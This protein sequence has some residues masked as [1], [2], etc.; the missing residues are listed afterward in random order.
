MQERT[1]KR[2]ETHETHENAR[3][4]ELAK[5]EAAARAVGLSYG[6]Y[7]AQAYMNQP[8]PEKA[9]TSPPEAR[10]RAKKYDD[11]E[12][13]ALWQAG[14]TDAEIASAF[15]VSR[16]IIQR[17]RDVLELPSTSKQA[18]DTKKFRLEKNRDGAYI[19]MREK[20]EI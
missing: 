7:K 16:T 19:V 17:W 2:T 9:A 1:S 5:D 18:V 6:Q 12:A 8:K 11:R 3:M 10:K 4:N 14:K 20:P 13:F 15:G